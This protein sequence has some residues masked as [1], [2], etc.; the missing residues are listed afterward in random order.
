ML[1]ELSI[2]NHSLMVLPKRIQRAEMGWAKAILKSARPAM[3][4]ARQTITIR[5]KKMESIKKEGDGRTKR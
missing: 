2:S 3:A 4:L 5:K 1:S